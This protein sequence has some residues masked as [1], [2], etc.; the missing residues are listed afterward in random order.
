LQPSF[1][2]QFK[3]DVKRCE[4]AHLPIDELKA[5]MERLIR[6]AALE[7]KHKDHQLTGNNKGFR[8][9]HIRPDWLLIYMTTATEITFTRTGSHAELFGK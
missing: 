7:A 1:T 9:C 8:D 4:K 5:V 6:C 3:K 2:S